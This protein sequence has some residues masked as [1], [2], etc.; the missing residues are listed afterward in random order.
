ML[1]IS[2]SFWGLNAP[3]SWSKHS[4]LA[5]CTKKVKKGSNGMKFVAKF[6]KK[7]VFDQ[8]SGANT[9]TLVERLID[10]VWLPYKCFMAGAG[11]E[12]GSSDHTFRES[13]P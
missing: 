3:K 1:Y 9:R 8:R 6:S 13:E 2:T 11:F 4:F 10:F 7:T 5:F 12:T